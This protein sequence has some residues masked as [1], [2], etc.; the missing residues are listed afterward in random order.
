ML[1]IHYITF[2]VKHLE[3]ALDILE[4][5]ADCGTLNIP[6]IF[7]RFYTNNYVMYCYTMIYWRLMAVMSEGL[8][9]N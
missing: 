9:F 7:Q 3:Y 2:G 4:N 1:G 5:F 8:G 6:C